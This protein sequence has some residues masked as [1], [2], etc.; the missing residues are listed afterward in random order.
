MTRDEGAAAF[1]RSVRPQL[2]G[3]LTLYCGDRH[4][5]E[6]LAQDTLVRVWDRWTQIERLPAREAYVHRMAINAANSRFR[7]LGAERR[8]HARVGH[9]RPTQADQAAGLAVRE[10]VAALPR[11]QRTVLVLRYFADLPVDK[12]ARL[13]GCAPGTVKSLT[14]KAIA[15]LRAAGLVDSEEV[16]DRA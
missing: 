11:R 1:C 3:V 2:V 14:H 10:A 6:E 16:V 8:A 4:V 15:A 9:Q 5:A 7:R 12:V 13:M